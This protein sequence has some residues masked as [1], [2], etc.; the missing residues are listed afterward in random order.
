MDVISMA[1][2]LDKFGFPT[3]IAALVIV[4]IIWLVKHE[5]KRDEEATKERAAD[6]AQR[7]ALIDMIVAKE[8]QQYP[9]HTEA[10]EKE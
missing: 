1:E 4:G 5:S 2:A 9:V 6:A 7:Q 3:V 10:Q 8:K